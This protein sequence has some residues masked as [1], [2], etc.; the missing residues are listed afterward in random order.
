LIGLNAESMPNLCSI[1]YLG[2]LS[3]YDICHMKT[4]RFSQKK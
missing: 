4:S 1:T 3:I 2:I